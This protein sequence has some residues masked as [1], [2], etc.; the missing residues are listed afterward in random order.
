MPYENGHWLWVCR[1]PLRPM[2]RLPEAAR[3]FE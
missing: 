3:H 1:G 2:T